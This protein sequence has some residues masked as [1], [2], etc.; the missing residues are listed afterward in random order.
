MWSTFLC[1]SEITSSN[2]K[3]FYESVKQDASEKQFWSSGA[4]ID[5]WVDI[6]WVNEL[7][8]K[9]NLNFCIKIACFLQKRHKPAKKWIQ[10]MMDQLVSFCQI[11][12]CFKKAFL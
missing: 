3:Y 6:E 2:L 7:L 5:F 11:K 1:D 9:T 8:Y 10:I 4:K 12:I